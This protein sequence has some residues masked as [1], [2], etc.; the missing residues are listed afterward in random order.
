MTLSGD[1]F[2]SEE[3]KERVK[4]DWSV[5]VKT[6]IEEKNFSSAWLYVTALRG[7]DNK[8]KSLKRAFTCPLRGGE[9]YGLDIDNYE[10]PSWKTVSLLRRE[11]H[12]G[13][14]LVMAWEA[15]GNFYGAIGEKELALNCN[16]IKYTIVAIQSAE[17]TLLRFF[18]GNGDLIKK[19]D[20]EILRY[21][22]LYKKRK[23]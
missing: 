12:Y 4:I 20:E 22:E 9:A 10:T 1:F 6:L 2:V 19:Y 21:I 5:V 14:H 18:G 17:S 23:R 13:D 11:Q 15:L 3:E 16:V 7:P 8:N